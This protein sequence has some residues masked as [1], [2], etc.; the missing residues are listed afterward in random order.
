MPLDKIKKML[1]TLETCDLPGLFVCVKRDTAKAEAAYEDLHKAHE[2]MSKFLIDENAEWMGLL[3]RFKM[4]VNSSESE[5]EKVLTHH[6]SR[7][8]TKFLDAFDET[9]EISLTLS[10][11]EVSDDSDTSS[12][13][14]DAPHRSY[15][16]Q[17][18]RRTGPYFMKGPLKKRG[19]GK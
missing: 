17:V 4:V 18:D 12:S 19:T 11:P 16:D 13:G 8:S 10:G 1:E 9:C 3:P 5:D 2:D 14:S 7:P 15:T 6:V